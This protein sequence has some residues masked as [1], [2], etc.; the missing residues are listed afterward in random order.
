VSA[1]RL[2]NIIAQGV[3]SGHQGEFLQ[4]DARIYPGNSGGPLVNQ[5][6]EVVGINTMKELTRK[7]EGLGYALSIRIPLEEF[8]R[9][10]GLPPAP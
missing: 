8:A 5:Q 4:T 2:R 7:F 9:I 1:G 3:L 6:G 10:P